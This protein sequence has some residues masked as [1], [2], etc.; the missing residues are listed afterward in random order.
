MSDTNKRTAFTVFFSIEPMVNNGNLTDEQAGK[1]F[2]AM[3]RYAVAREEPD[4]KG[5]PLVKM[6]FDYF[7]SC[8][9]ENLRKWNVTREKRKAA[10][11]T[12]WKAEREKN[13]GDAF[14]TASPE[15]LGLPFK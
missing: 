1:L 5:D 6:A 12:R 7:R 14:L 10:A 3:L 13:G 11:D 8:D 2:K 4:F 9:D 15:D